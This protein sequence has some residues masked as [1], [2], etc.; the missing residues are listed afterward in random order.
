MFIF[1]QGEGGGVGRGGGGGGGR[2]Y[3]LTARP[4]RLSRGAA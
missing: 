4:N 2:V 3:R 1:L